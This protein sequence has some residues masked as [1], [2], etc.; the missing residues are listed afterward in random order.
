MQCSFVVVSSATSPA[1]FAMFYF[2]VLG[3]HRLTFCVTPQRS[4]KLLA[5]ELAPT[6]KST[7]VMFSEK[8]L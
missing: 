1:E 5:S 8:L 7:A 4:I 6:P 3:R 2:V